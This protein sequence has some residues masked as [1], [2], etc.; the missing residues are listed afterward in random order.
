MSKLS[1]SVFWVALLIL[2]LQFAYQIFL[3]KADSQTT[4]EAVHLAAGYTYLTKEDY[5]F[6]SEH[7]PLIKILAAIPLLIIKPNMPIDQTTYNN[8]GNFFYDSWVENR[9]FGEDWFYR[10]DNNPDQLLFW[11]R[12]PTIILAFFLGLSIFFL[13]RRLWG[14]IAGLIAV[15]FYALDP[16]I[17]AQ[18]HLITTDIG[19]SL[20]ILLSVISYWAFLNSPNLK[21]ALTWGLI[22][23]LTLVTK[24]TTILLI[25]I[26]LA[27]TI[28]FLLKKGK[29]VAKRFLGGLLIALM[30]AYLVVVA[31]YGFDFNM[32]PPTNHVVELTTIVNHGYQTTGGELIDKVYPIIRHLLIPK[33]YF[34][35]LV[36]ILLHV[37]NGHDSF[38]LGQ[39]SN[40]GWWYYFPVIFLAKTPLP[41]L[42]FLSLGL[43]LAFKEKSARSKAW[44]LVIAAVIYLLLAMLSKANLGVRH[45]LPL[46]PFLLITASCLI[47]SNL[48]Y[49]A[50]VASG[51]MLLLL[52]KFV[53]EF[54]HPISSYNYLWG[55]VSNG[56]N[57]ATDSNY[58]W[59]Q[60][61]KRIKNYLE[62]SSIK[63][64][65]VEYGWNSEY[66]LDYYQI[67]RRPLNQLAIDKSG[68]LIIGAS[69]VQS[70]DYQ[71]LKSQ[72]LVDRIS[73]SVFVYQ[74]HE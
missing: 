21:K 59:G 30:T 33:Y 8:S 58:D 29:L 60:D 43:Y 67:Q 31:V 35:G 3:A 74:L 28:Y 13:A 46:Y 11:G 37:G 63:M 72:E 26:F 9:Q 4:D 50:Y 51:L 69:A 24:F 52:I 64:P 20:G 7:P 42:I 23:G 49:R 25:P 66:S 2:G 38:L 61:V 56:Y 40:S 34:K 10:S 44:Y 57:I 65:Y 6:N 45:I 16:N 48:R 68:Y 62:H 14:E 54:N 18:A 53:A 55:G 70:K 47:I 71:W 17:N 12:L 5:R 22:F 32:A 1:R 36:M 41:T 39:H 15:G 19:A 27:L 73:P